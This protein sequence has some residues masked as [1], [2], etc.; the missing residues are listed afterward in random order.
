MAIGS[1][2]G[3]SFGY[4]EESTYGT[5]V[6]PTRWNQVNKAD[7][8]KVKNVVQGGGLAASRLVQAGGQRAVPT[9]GAAGSVEIEV[10]YTKLGLLI[11]HLMGSAATPVQQAATAAYLQTHV[12]GDNFGKKLTGQVGVP[13]RDG[14]VRPQTF[15][16]GKILAAEF[17]CKVNELL[18][19]TLD[20]DFQKH[21]EVETLATPTYTAA[22]PFHFGN[23]AVKIG[24]YGAT[25][26]VTGVKGVTC[27][28]E[29]GLD[30]EGWYANGAGLKVEPVMN[31][32][33]KISGSL[34]IDYMNKTDFTDRFHTDAGFA[35][36]LEWVGPI[37]ASTYAYTFRIRL[38]Q[39][40]LDDGTQGLDG[41]DV[42]SGSFPFTVQNDLTNPIC[43]IEYM[44]T[45][46]TA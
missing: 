15:K 39:V 3:G 4:A 44:S 33:V 30:T 42:V 35:M 17:S 1:G 45:D 43:S 21:S 20:L 41:P 34:D 2:L 22:T 25:A 5:Y 7:I 23:L 36:D 10:P 18:T 16:G 40:F 24:T 32:W 31:D 27:K 14:T 37:I 19:A 28:I 29:R 6:A 38:G 11:Q 46:T 9:E 13:S 8:K 26:A 12:L